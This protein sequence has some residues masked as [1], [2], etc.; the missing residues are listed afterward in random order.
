MARVAGN[1]S[2]PDML[3]SIEYAVEHL[4]V[5]LLVVLGHEHCGAVAAAL[6]GEKPAGNLGALISQ[7]YVGKQLPKEKEAAQAA[8]EKN[9]VLHL[10]ELVTRHSDV[11]KKAVE[12]KR[13]NVVT[14]IYH[15]D[16]GKVEWLENK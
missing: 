4:H 5:P 12:E 16:T 10:S 8:A 13:L 9:N 15:L 11:L 7:I 1:V 14:A 2:D 6:G 3:G